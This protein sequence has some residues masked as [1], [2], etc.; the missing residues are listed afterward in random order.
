MRKNELLNLVEETLTTKEA[1]AYIYAHYTVMDNY[2]I[3]KKLNLNI[4]EFYR[5]L[6][7]ANCK[8]KKALN[9]LPIIEQSNVVLK[10]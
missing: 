1:D 5:I 7:S 10:D 2:S 6:D 3:A 9:N 8:M 4:D